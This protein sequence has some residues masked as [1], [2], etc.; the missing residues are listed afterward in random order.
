MNHLKLNKAA[1]MLLIL[2][3]V[4]FSADFSRRLLTL[5]SAQNRNVL[6]PPLPV[7]LDKTPY[8]ISQISDLAEKWRP[9][10]EETESPIPKKLADHNSRQFGDVQL[11]LLA[12]YT[13]G[14]FTALLRY[15]SMSEPTPKLVR[16]KAGQNLEQVDIA[17]IER[18]QVTLNFAGQTSVLTLFRPKQTNLQP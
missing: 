1:L 9:I 2:L 10:A 18:H 8:T 3:L 17:A 5:P 14:E 6:Q 4:L 12:I 7:F 11:I 15:S 13:E 16:V